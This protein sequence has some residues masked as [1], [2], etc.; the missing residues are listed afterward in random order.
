MVDPY[1]PPQ[2]HLRRPE[3]PRYVGFWARTC[4]SIVDWVLIALITIPLLYLVYG[5][6]YFDSDQIV[7]GSWDVILNYVFPALAV[8]LFWRYRSATPG[9]MLVGAI[10][11]DA[12]SGGKPSTGQLVGRYLGYFVSLLVLGLG[13]LWVAWDPKKQGWHDKLAGTVVVKRPQN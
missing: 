9:K 1:V 2:S 10:I 5:A 6:N 7:Q 3:V 4:A 12:E 13:Y 8:L 11:V